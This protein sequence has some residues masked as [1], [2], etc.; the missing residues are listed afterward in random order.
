[1]HRLSP[2]HVRH[3]GEQGYV[4][5]HQPVFEPEKFARLSALF[6]EILAGAGCRGDELDTPHFREPRLLEFLLDDAVLDLVEPLIGPNIGLWSSHFISK[7]PGTGRR[8]PWHTDAHYWQGRFE[9]IT[10]IVTVWLAIDRAD[11]ANGAM[12]V[13]P[14]SH[15]W[16]AAQYVPLDR[17]ENLF[18]QGIDAGQIDE[19]ASVCFEL[20]PN[21]CSLHDSRIIHGA[22][23]NRSDRRRCGYTMRYFDLAMRYNTEVRAEHKLW[24]ARG[25]NVGG[26]PLEY[27]G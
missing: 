21:E 23:P 20:D 24:H 18:A 26:S 14:G 2:D 11:E 7:E 27:A 8:T 22:Q 4:L 25:E 19:S 6:E 1:M 9:N 17:S 3:Y 12:R 16:P 10:T 13:I 5:Y 15:T